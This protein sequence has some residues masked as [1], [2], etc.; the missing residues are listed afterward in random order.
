MTIEQLKLADWLRKNHILYIGF[1]LGG[2]LGLIA[3]LIMRSNMATILSVLIPFIIGSAFYVAFRF[4]ETKW[5][6]QSLPYILLVSTFAVSL[7]V[8]LLSE[9]NLGSVGIIFFLLVF[10]GIHGRLLIM[11]VAYVL[12]L[13]ALVLNNLVFVSPDLVSGSGANLILLHFLSGM[14]LM[15]VV[16]QNAKNFSEIERFTEQ[17]EALRKE[18]AELAKRLDMTVE[19]ITSNLGKLRDSSETS[20]G[21]QREM[22]TAI[23]EVSGASQHQADYISDIAERSEQTHESV[24]KISGGLTLLVQKANEAGG[25]ADEGSSRIAGLKNG[26]DAFAHF[27]EELN[28]TFLVLSEKIAETNAFAGS[29]KEITDQTNLLALNASIEAARAGE[30]GKGFAVVADEIRKLA[31]M[32]DSTLSKI[33]ANLSEVNTFNQLAV[34]KLSTGKEQITEQTEVADSSNTT[35]TALHGEMRDLQKEMQSFI[36]SFKEITTNTDTVRGHTMEF[37]SVIEESTATIEEL[38]ATL[39]HLVEE[40]SE[41]DRY[42]QE[43]HNEAVSLHA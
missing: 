32:T 26:I 15:L 11:G 36:E 35:F 17:T 7:G 29:I 4:T 23:Q 24:E 2:G 28:H 8:I 10:G 38:D 5:L 40:Q 18:E 41:I 3:Q 1:A 27:F 33:D 37:A 20:L 42:L 21:A 13:A 14:I 39:T 34:S 30:H 31:G 25:R 12:S 22:L 6:M 43:T 16:R 9:A 19:K